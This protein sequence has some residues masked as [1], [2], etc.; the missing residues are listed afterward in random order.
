MRRKPRKLVAVTQWVRTDDSSPTWSKPS[1]QARSA[2][3]VH[4]QP[5]AYEAGGH[6]RRQAAGWSP[7][8]NI[9]VDTRISL[10][11]VR[12]GKPTVFTSRK[13]AV[14]KTRGRVFR[15]PPGSKSGACLHRGNS[16]TWESHLSPC[17]IPGVGTG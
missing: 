10:Q 15:T 4:T 2:L 7:E 1:Q 12:R 17:H 11:G 6:A 5:W 3:H 14:L 13:A 16:G 9:V 8:K